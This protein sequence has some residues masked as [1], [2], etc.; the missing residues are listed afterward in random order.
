MCRF[1]LGSLAYSANEVVPLLVGDLFQG[2]LVVVAQEDGPLARVGDD[3]RLGEDLGDRVPL[4]PANRHEQAR[5]QGEVEAE[6]ALV[7]VAEVVGHV[8]RPSV[9]FGQQ[10]PTRVLRRR[11]ACV[12]A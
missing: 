3:R 2:E 9:G 7:P 5:H 1:I 6:V 8:G 12:R 4:L 11:T 10:D